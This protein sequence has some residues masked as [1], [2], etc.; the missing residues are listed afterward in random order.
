M[1]DW[2]RQL[3]GAVVDSPLWRVTTCIAG[4]WSKRGVAFVFLLSAPGKD[5]SLSQLTWSQRTKVVS[6]GVNS[7]GHGYLASSVEAEHQF[8]R[9]IDC[10]HLVSVKGGDLL[11]EPTYVEGG[12]L[13][14]QDLRSITQD[15]NDGSH[16]R[17][18]SDA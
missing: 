11:T 8:Q 4:N 14:D 6:S 5:D 13:L 17:L 18:S 1:S 7:K 12:N 3:K 9:I 16:R 10:P 2:V 15:L